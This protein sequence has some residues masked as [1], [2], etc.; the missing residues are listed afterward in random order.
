MRSSPIPVS[1]EG[2]GSGCK[3]PCLSRLNCIK[4]KF[5]IST[6]LSPSASGV[7]GGPPATSGPWSKKISVQGPQGPVSPIDQKLSLSPQREKRC[8]DTPMSFNQ[9]SAASSSFSYTV[10][11]SFSGGSCKQTVKNSQ[12]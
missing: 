9:I 12:A 7:P 11:H 8:A 4:T 1:T 3:W 10:I 6:Y 2:L 5:Q